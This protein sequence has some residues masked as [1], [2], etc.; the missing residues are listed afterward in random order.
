MRV[1]IL[2]VLATAALAQERH[3]LLLA[4]DM[5]GDHPAGTH[6]YAPSLEAL[7]RDLEPAGVRCTLVPGGWP[8]DEALFEGVDALVLYSDGADRDL[9]RH[10]FL[11]QPGRLSTLRA[12]RAQG[13]GLVALH[14]STIVPNA[15]LGELLLAWTGGHFDH[16]SGPPPNNW[17]SR[18][19]HAQGS[20]SVAVDDHPVT[21]GLAAQWSQHDE[22]YYDLR[23]RGHT[24]LVQVELEGRPKTVAWCRD[25][26]GARGF[27]FTGG[28]AVASYEHPQGRRLLL[29]A[30]LWAAQ[31]EVPATG[32]PITRQPVLVPG[33][34][35]HALDCSRTDVAFAPRED[36]A[37]SPFSV[38]AFVR[39]ATPNPFQ[40]FVSNHSKSSGAHWELYAYAGRG[41]LALYLPGYEP[42]EIRSGRPICDD[43]WHHV[44][45]TFDGDEVALF[46]DGEEVKRAAVRANGKPVV[47]GPLLVGAAVAADHS[48]GCFGLVDEL[49]LS[50]GL[51]DL[52]QVPA[53][54]FASDAR[55]IGLW[56]FDEQRDDGFRDHSAFANPSAFV[57]P[58]DWTPRV[59][60]SP[61]AQPYE[62]ETDADWHDDRIARMDTGPWLAH[63]FLVDGVEG[64]AQVNKGLAVKLA[65]ATL[66][67]DL[68][69]L[70]LVSAWKGTPLV[71]SDV[72]FGL[73]NKPRTGGPSEIGAPPN[74]GLARLLELWSDADGVALV[75][76]RDGVRVVERPG[77]VDG[78]I[79]RVISAGELPAQAGV[80][81]MIDQRAAEH[82]PGPRRYPDLVTQGVVDEAL[83]SAYAVDTLSLPH[84]NPWG[85]LLFASGVDFL[86]N[87][88]GVICTAHG[89]VWTVSGIDADL[90][91]LRWRRFATGLYQPLGLEVVDGQVLVLGR[92]RITRLHDTDG[93]GEADRY[94]S[95]N[96]DLEVV[97][98]DHAY[99]MDFER[100]PDGAFYFQKSGG[101]NTAHGGCTLRVAPDGSE[102]TV[103]AH[104]F[105]HANGIGVSP[106]GVVTNA[107]N[108]GGFIPTTRINWITEPG[109]HGGFHRSYRGDGD[110][111]AYDPPLCWL[112]QSADSS[113]GGQRW[114]EGDRW[115][116]PAGTML[117][118]SFGHARLFVVLPETVAGVAQ[119]GAVA[120]PFTFLSGVCRG[121]FRPQDGQLYVAGLDGWQTA[122]VR[123]GCLQR[124]RYT[125][126]EVDLPIDLQVREGEL[127]LTFATDLDP[128]SVTAEAFTVSR[129]NYRYS[130][131]Y[132]SKEWSAA[133]PDREGHDPV[134]VTAARLEGRT[135]VLTIPSQAP[136]MQQEVLWS[137]RSRAG[138]PLHGTLHHTIHRLDRPGG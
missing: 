32:V 68:E 78:R 129:W 57:P 90:D 138:D 19:T 54:P 15:G 59:K 113:A 100:G 110:P 108:E 84:D 21:R 136:V 66:L 33:R 135:L 99:A 9:S 96:A 29:N 28:H 126:G 24:P 120:F 93:N 103:L 11:A 82:R 53:E 60:A 80:E 134:T 43:E 76:E 115:G 117:H 25:A 137:L 58:P 123:D 10:P 105:R 101:T 73:L 46:L 5:A 122:A 4:G 38:E 56:H 45:F 37:A 85:A 35:G 131:D 6:E 12:L 36:Y 102:L 72:R 109:Y 121:A 55:T 77:F 114:V 23:L 63:S 30:I 20:V 91:E 98:E 106:D 34:F 26:D 31:A 132:G 27:G 40:V 94:E 48:V 127:R 119:G 69:T 70:E 3:V 111:N 41:D 112:P 107:D 128:A 67:Y 61:E 1:L 65:G 7:V 75:Y 50:S 47:P 133:H 49:R 116:L 86:P 97:G 87:G 74:A 17:F 2:L 64:R 89:D 130:R 39:S 81:V 14:W 52:T 124:V 62:V 42:S 13:C 118:T 104:G 18:I 83:A 44:G 95:F 88:D 125:G 8:E 71:F 16:Q 92:D 79:R 51:R 22:W